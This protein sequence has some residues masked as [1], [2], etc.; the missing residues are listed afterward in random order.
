MHCAVAQA[1]AS[2]FA[3]LMVNLLSRSDVV[4]RIVRN[5]DVARKARQEPQMHEDQQHFEHFLQEL[6]EAL[7]QEFVPAA[8]ND[9]IEAPVG[10]EPALA[11]FQQH[12]K[13]SRSPIRTTERNNRNETL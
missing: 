13:R 10:W 12:R 11:L 5:A 1:S 7:Q 2:H 3:M 6:E 8:E 4:R 9:T